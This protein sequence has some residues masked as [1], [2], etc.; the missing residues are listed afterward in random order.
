MIV[1]LK[2]TNGKLVAAGSV[3]GSF[4]LGW[5]LSALFWETNLYNFRDFQTIWSSVFASIGGLSIFVI[6]SG[7][8][9]HQRELHFSQLNHQ[10]ELQD[11]EIANERVKHEKK[12]FG[13]K[14]LIESEI[15]HNERQ[16]TAYL[17]NSPD[18]VNETGSVETPRV[19]DSTKSM[20]LEYGGEIWADDPEMLSALLLQ[21]QAIESVIVCVR[22]LVGSLPTGDAKAIGNRYQAL[23]NVI[24]HYTQ[25]GIVERLR[26]GMN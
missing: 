11:E 20:Y 5:I 23:R 17:A 12:L 13:I 4:G 19:L 7:N 3:L 2:K 24:I 21:Y 22:Q 8:L 14:K 6:A 25:S 15:D 26:Q 18:K 9:R 10:K 16:L 1:D